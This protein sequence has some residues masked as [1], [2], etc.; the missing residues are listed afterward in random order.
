MSFQVVETL[1]TVLSDLVEVEVLVRAS[2]DDDVAARTV[3]QR[4]RLDSSGRAFVELRGRP[5]SRI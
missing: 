2:H 5:K 1:R 3:A 4:R